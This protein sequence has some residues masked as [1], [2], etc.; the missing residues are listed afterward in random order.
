MRKI[1]LTLTMSFFII[2]S[3]AG[4]ILTL[5]NKMIFE[6]KALKI[7]GCNLVFKAKGKKYIIPATDIFSVQFENPENKIYTEYI[8]LA[9]EDPDKCLRGRLD[10]ELYHGKKG[11][12]FVLGVLFGPFAMI[13]TALANPTPEKGKQTYLMSEN[14][15]EFNDPAYLSCYVKKAKAQL[16]GIEALGWAAWILIALSL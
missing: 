4:D 7:K 11:G 1:A 15:E 9:D 13:G 14:K 12:H 5:N 16:I 8:K 2:A 6:G 10:A 3:Y